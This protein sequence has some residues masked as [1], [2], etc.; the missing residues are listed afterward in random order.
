[1]LLI[2]IVALVIIALAVGFGSAVG[3]AVNNVLRD[4][5]EEK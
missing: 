1:M 5:E 2:I 3:S 4:D